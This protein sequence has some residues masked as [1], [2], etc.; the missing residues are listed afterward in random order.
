M[1]CKIRSCLL[2]HLLAAFVEEHFYLLVSDMLL[3]LLDPLEA[4]AA[5]TDNQSRP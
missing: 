3:N 2:L 5:R 1:L 4:D